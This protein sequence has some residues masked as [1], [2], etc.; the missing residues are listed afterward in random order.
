MKWCALCG[1]PVNSN[2]AQGWIPWHKNQDGLRCYCPTTSSRDWKAAERREEAEA[3]GLPGD[4]GKLLGCLEDATHWLG[5]LNA[6]FPEDDEAY[7]NPFWSELY[8]TTK[9]LGNMLRDLQAVKK[10]MPVTTNKRLDKVEE[11]CYDVAA[12]R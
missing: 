1:E 5:K 6:Q 3:K 8:E 2:S 10:D 4:F 7:D 12:D 9:P 11:S